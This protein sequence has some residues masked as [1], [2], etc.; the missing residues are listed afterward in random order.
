MKLE[1][2]DYAIRA[3]CGEV[4]D[5]NRQA[6]S[7]KKLSEEELLY[8]VAVCVFSSQMVFE[9]A[10]AAVDRLKQNRLLCVAC[11]PSDIFHYQSIVRQALEEPLDVVVNSK[12]RKL[13]P[14]FRNRISALLARTVDNIYG[15]GSSIK[16]VLKGAY[17]ARNA[18]ELL[19]N[20]VSG[21]GPKQ[22]SLYLRRIG[23]SA[24]LAV[25]DTHVLDYMKLALGVK[26]KRSLLSGVSGYERLETEF[27]EIAD[28]FGYS[29]GCVDLALWITMRVAKREYIL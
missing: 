28:K 13:F 6:I 23:Y 9:V 15:G 16:E 11:M 2:L 27:R 21:F 12:R 10:V 8:E 1:A 17:S 18:R 4:A 5:S 19:I 26:P 7:W 24:D 29:I 25:L 22:A 20:A 14:R 3:M